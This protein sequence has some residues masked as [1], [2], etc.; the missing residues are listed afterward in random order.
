MNF[1]PPSEQQARMLWTSLT[2]LA[3]AILAGLIGVL[4][5][6]FAWVVDRLSSVLLPLA[7]AGIIAY[8]LDPVV[9]FFERRSVSRARAILLVFTLLGLIILLL[10]ATIVPRLI[11]E[12]G[13]LIDKVPEYTQAAPGKI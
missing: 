12:T 10:L 8:V 11:Y 1:T 13:E 5:W 3:V 6:G 4:L 2:W 9:D 7:I